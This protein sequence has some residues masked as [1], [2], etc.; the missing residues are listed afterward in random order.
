MANGTYGIVRPA[1]ITPD[2]VE[3]FYHF[4]ASRDSIGNTTLQRLDPNEVL[5]KVNNPNRV[6][7]GI[8]GFEVFGGMYTLKLPTA[9]FGTKGFYTIVIKPIE[10]RT[11]IVDVGVL[12]AYPDTKGLVFDISSIP[13]AF[14]NRFENNGLVGYIIEYLN[15]TTNTNDAKINNFYRVITSNNRAEPVN[16]NLTNSS[17]KAIRY[18][19]NDNSTLTYCTVTPSSA[20]NVNPNVFPFIGQPNQQVIITNT[21]FNPLMVEIEMV[22]HDVE[23]LA[24]AMFGN[25]TKSLDD[26]IYTIYNFNNDIY[27]QYSLYEIKDVY[28]GTPLFEVREALKSVDFSKTFNTIT[29]I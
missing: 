26:G 18:R 2:D 29:T 19:F 27:K 4:S 16:Q 5:I 7:S 14:A 10:I 6:Q 22:Q 3:I 21:F 20:S 9:T 13:T 17:Q 23:T 28:T 1:D 8:S 12:S 25:Q 15:T 24:F 11:R